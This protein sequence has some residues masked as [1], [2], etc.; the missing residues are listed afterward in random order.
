MQRR[1]Q[2]LDKPCAPQVQFVFGLQHRRPSAPRV[3]TWLQHQAL[4]PYFNAAGRTVRFRR[5]LDAMPVP[6]LQQLTTA[7]LDVEREELPASSMYL[8][9]LIE[10][11]SLLKLA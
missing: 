2:Q 11:L 7:R 3:V 6:R 4:A 10:L 5:F 8:K 9:A 1:E